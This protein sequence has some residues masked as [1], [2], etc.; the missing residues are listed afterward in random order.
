MKSI[1][2]EKNN[3]YNRIKFEED[4][5]K[6]ELMKIQSMIKNNNNSKEYISKVIRDLNEEQIQ[7]LKALYERDIERLNTR[8]NSNKRKMMSLKAEW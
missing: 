6:A 3:F 1:F 5:D 8:I 7:K 4:P 2:E